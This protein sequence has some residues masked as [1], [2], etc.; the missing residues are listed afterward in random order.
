MGDITEKQKKVYEYLIEKASTG[1]PPTVREIAAKIGIKSTSTVHGILSA[2][3][4]KGLIERDRYNSR[5]IKIAGAKEVRQ[6]P[7]LGKVTAGEPILAFEDI[8]DYI[9]FTTSRGDGI[10]A[11]N[12]TGLSM[13]NAGIMDGDI[14]VADKQAST[15]EGDIVVALIEDEATVKRLAFENGKAVLMPENEDF[16]PIRPDSLEI[17]GKVIGCIRKY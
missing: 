16:S 13:K 14:V 8:K 11:L 12:V 3:E 2:L 15:R 1:L 6:I 17:L 5:A 9:P 4:Q 10:F 7:V